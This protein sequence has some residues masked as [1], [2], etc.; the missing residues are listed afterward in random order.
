MRTART[1]EAEWWQVL[2]GSVSAGAK[3][4]GLSTGR[5]FGCWVLSCYGPFSLGARLETYKQFISLIFQIFLA[6]VNRR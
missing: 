6:T 5:V 4:D 3:E 2:R 1:L